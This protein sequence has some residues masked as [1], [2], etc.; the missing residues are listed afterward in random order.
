MKAGDI[1]NIGAAT[2][3]PNATLADAAR[4]MTQ[5][6]I[7]GLPVVDNGG[8]L[9]GVITE[10]DFL[11][12]ENGERPRWFDVLLV[13]KGA[14][15]SAHELHNAR[16]ED[17]MSKNPIAVQT[18]TPV[19]ELVDVMQR[20]GVKRLP[21]LAQGR[22]VGIVSRANLLEALLRKADNDR[23]SRARASS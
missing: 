16:V 22:I 12:R 1:M 15:I 5:H 2:I 14:Q 9:I 13:E 19:E 18:E 23:P 3:R 21:V 20:H 7:S 17:V 4:L 11:R 6:H 8:T 10:H